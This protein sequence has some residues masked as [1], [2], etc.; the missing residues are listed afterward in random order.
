MTSEEK[1]ICKNCILP[2]HFLSIG[3]NDAGLCDF[4]A[5]SHHKTENWKKTFVDEQKRRDC[6]DQWNA[7]IKKLQK[8]KDE[9]A[10]LLGYSGGKDST[11]LVDTF[12]HQYH[13]KPFLITIDTGFM[14]EVAK[15]NIRQTLSKLN[16]EDSHLFI[17]DAAPVFTELYKYIFL[18]HDSNEKALTV[19]VCHTCT[20]LIHTI[21]VKEAMKRGI[22]Y[23]IIG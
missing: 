22:E 8:T 1:I 18:N 21:L 20:D 2:N 5:D 15:E 4:C 23:V 16:M 19:D 9:Y 12:L 3:V 11:A 7:L 10:V 6:L 13:L 17:E 14:T